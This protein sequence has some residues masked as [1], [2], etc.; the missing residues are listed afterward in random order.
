MDKKY[1][2]SQK[3]SSK[4]LIF[5]DVHVLVNVKTFNQLL[6]GPQ[7]SRLFADEL[8][9]ILSGEISYS[10]SAVIASVFCVLFYNRHRNEETLH[11]EA[12]SLVRGRARSKACRAFAQKTRRSWSQLSKRSLSPPPSFTGQ[13]T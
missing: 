2:K 7:E 12:D 4:L 5:R 9:T 1:I 6:F 3:G 8:V 13:D 10:I 11:S